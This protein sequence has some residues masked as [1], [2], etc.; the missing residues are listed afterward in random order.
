M[1]FRKIS[2]NHL[3][4]RDL[5]ELGPTPSAEECTQLKDFSDEQDHSDM[6]KEVTAYLEQLQRTFGEPPPQAE[7]VIVRNT[8]DFGTYYEAGVMFNPDD[9]EASKYAYIMESN[10]PETWDSIAT[11]SL[12]HREHSR[13]YTPFRIPKQKIA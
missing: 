11:T 13:Y 2:Y 3:N 10:L 6:I 9:N 12:M 1:Y 7:L 8:H 4:G 5:L